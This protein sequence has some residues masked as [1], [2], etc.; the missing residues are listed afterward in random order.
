[1]YVPVH[2]T[3]HI[4]YF[5][6]YYRLNLVINLCAVLSIRTVYICVDNLWKTVNGSIK[7]SIFHVW[8]PYISAFHTFRCGLFNLVDFPPSIALAIHIKRLPITKWQ[9]WR[10]FSIHMTEGWI[11]STNSNSL[12]LSV[13]IL[14]SLLFLWV[15]VFGRRMNETEFEV[16]TWKEPIFLLS[17][18]NQHL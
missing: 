16:K 3:W 6:S 17:F 5:Y 4:E 15:L 14:K 11:I 12:N 10:F 7:A 9:R 18:P 2:W 1:M 8:V 13:L